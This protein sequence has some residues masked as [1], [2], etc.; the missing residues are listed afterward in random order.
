[1]N[2]ERLCAELQREIADLN[3]NR[4]RLEFILNRKRRE[5]RVMNDRLAG[6]RREFAAARVALGDTRLTSAR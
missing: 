6:A 1:M 3:N 5:L 2:A 4:H